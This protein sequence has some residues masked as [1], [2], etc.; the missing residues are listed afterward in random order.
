MKPYLAESED[1]APSSDQ[2]CISVASAWS[3]DDHI[4]LQG[5]L[6][7]SFKPYTHAPSADQ[8]RVG[9]SSVRPREAGENAA[10]SAGLAIAGGFIMYLIVCAFFG[11]DTSLILAVICWVIV[12]RMVLVK[13]TSSSR[14][15]NDSDPTDR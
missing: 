6:D 4:S 15:A 13:T 3:A 8:P 2:R 1:S 5:F 7:N 9:R 11:F 14:D 12:L 10:S